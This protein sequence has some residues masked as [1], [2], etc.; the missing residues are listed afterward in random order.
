MENLIHQAGASLPCPL[1]LPDSRLVHRYISTLVSST[2]EYTFPL[3]GTSNQDQP[4]QGSMSEDSTSEGDVSECGGFRRSS[5]VSTSHSVKS[6]FSLSTAVRSMWQQV[7][8]SKPHFHRGFSTLHYFVQGCA[9]NNVCGH[10][11]SCHICGENLWD[12][13]FFAYL[14]LFPLQ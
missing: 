14:G 12:P 6:T 9:K 7:I 5:R 8:E 10:K 3:Q 4:Q 1:S 13:S 11:K 2:Q